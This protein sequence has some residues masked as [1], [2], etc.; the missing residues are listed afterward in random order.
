MFLALFLD[1]DAICLTSFLLIV[2]L[3]ITFPSLAFASCFNDGFKDDTGFS[4]SVAARED[5]KTAP[6]IVPTIFFFM[7]KSPLRFVITKI[8]V[9]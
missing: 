9:I 1:V 8:S 4:G 5:N 2:R 3:A 6:V 7:I